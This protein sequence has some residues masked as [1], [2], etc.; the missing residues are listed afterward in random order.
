LKK[1]GIQG[2]LS[3]GLLFKHLVG[4]I[5]TSLKDIVQFENVGIEDDIVLKGTFCQRI[6]AFYALKKL[7]LAKAGLVLQQSKCKNYSLHPDDCSLFSTLCN[8]IQGFGSEPISIP[9]NEGYKFCGKYFGNQDWRFRQIE[10]QVDTC[11]SNLTELEGLSTIQTQF[12]LLQVCDSSKLSHLLRL[13]PPSFLAP[14][15]ERWDEALVDWAMTKFNLPIHTRT[16][17]RSHLRRVL[18]PVR[19]AGIGL[20][21]LVRGAH[22]GFLC[23]WSAVINDGV[24]CSPSI[25]AAIEDLKLAANNS[26]EALRS[27]SA[28]GAEILAAIRQIHQGISQNE[29]NN[30]YPAPPALTAM[31]LRRLPNIHGSNFWSCCAD[32]GSQRKLREVD[33]CRRYQAELEAITTSVTHH[34]MLRESSNKKGKA[35]ATL[36]TKG[37]GISQMSDAA[38]RMKVCGHLGVPY[39]SIYRLLT[40]EDVDRSGQVFTACVRD[41]ENRVIPC[42][43]CNKNL[44]DN[45]GR[46]F[47]KCCKV[48]RSLTHNLSCLQVRHLIQTTLAIPTPVILEEAN[49]MIDGSSPN[50]QN[51]RSD[52]NALISGIMYVTDISICTNALQPN[53]DE[54]QEMGRSIRKREEQKRRKYSQ[55]RREYKFVPLVFGATGFVG[56][57]AA[58][59]F[60]ILADAVDSLGRIPIWYYW[61]NI[62]PEFLTVID[63]GNW[64]TH[65]TFFRTLNRRDNPQ[66]TRIIDSSNRR[67]FPSN[68]PRSYF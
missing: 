44:L 58:H 20:K 7:L 65:E 25:H 27:N 68:A 39:P 41:E 18:S 17:W 42:P 53:R 10:M 46:H 4:P 34:R 1:G 22:A 29:I 9:P 64:L 8:Q 14:L 16:L 49:L 31:Q 37:V 13:Y 24:A 45:L 38:F 61:Q 51:H 32:K 59:F 12:K 33:N 47:A 54:L 5:I 26:S 67:G 62:I 15:Y 55:L 36:R 21:S 35:G 11:I 3:T 56:T 23:A 50:L 40:P 63:I 48:N 66:R 19:Y 57:S 60:K 43:L 30:F 6:V 2:V 28:L 52:V